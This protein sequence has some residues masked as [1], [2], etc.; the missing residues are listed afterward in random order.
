MHFEVTTVRVLTCTSVSLY[1]DALQMSQS[2]LFEIN[3]VFFVVVVFYM[4][5]AHFLPGKMKQTTQTKICF[6]NNKQPLNA[7]S[8]L[9]AS[10]S[11]NN[12]NV[13]FSFEIFHL[14]NWQCHS[15]CL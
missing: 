12:I 1:H 11:A 8:F 6:Q 15:E 13:K 2:A 14:K 5:L 10:S 7:T 4:K 3:S 9:L